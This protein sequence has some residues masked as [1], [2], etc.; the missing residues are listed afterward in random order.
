MNLGDI[1]LVSIPVMVCL[2][3]KAMSVAELSRTMHASPSAVRR[4]VRHLEDAGFIIRRWDN[5]YALIVVLRVENLPHV[6]NGDILPGDPGTVV[7]SPESGVS[8]GLI[9]RQDA[10]SRVVQPKV[11]PT[12]AEAPYVAPTAPKRI[13]VSARASKLAAHFKIPEWRRNMGEVSTGS[14]APCGLCKTTTVVKY[15]NQPVCAPCA[16]K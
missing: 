16:R 4:W 11:V 7:F 15:G 8:K 3:Q 10:E 14:V 9:V 5:R 1:N 13:T 6:T 2:A 12:P